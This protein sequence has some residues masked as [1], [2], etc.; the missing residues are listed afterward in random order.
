MKENTFGFVLHPLD[1]RRDTSRK[2]PFLARMPAW[3]IEFVS[4][5]APPVLLSEIK[6]IRSSGNGSELRGWFVACPLSAR[7]MLMLPRAI[8]YHK[9]VQSARLAETLGARIVGLGAFTSVVGDGGVSVAR[10]VNVPVTTGNSYT[11]ATAIHA[12]HLASQ[13]AG[14]DL[15]R[16][17]V[18]IVGAGG[19]IGAVCARLLA[20]DSDTLLLIGRSLPSLQDAARQAVAS[21]GRNVRVS[22]VI[23]AI[24]E[25]QVVITVTSS[26]S[27]VV[28]AHH[29]GPNAIVCDVARPRDVARR[30]CAKRPDVHV[31]EGGVV[32]VP[33]TV[34]FGFDFGFPPGMAYACMAETMALA[35]AGRYESFSLGKQLE[36]DRV[37]EIDQLA[38]RHGFRLS[39]L[40][41]LDRMVTVPGSDWEKDR[42]MHERRVPS[43]ARSKDVTRLPS[44]P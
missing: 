43:S 22:T 23:N 31:I 14:I 41:N 19:S 34:D 11:V 24:K 7:M 9:I 35:L 16:A 2:Y 1:A 21:G 32:R 27:A 20:Q 3:L 30:V 28:D 33:G 40:R 29:L 37:K 12:V 15:S 44:I 25:A 13:L 4:I 5:F 8:V 18:A 10:R 38:A 42:A 36:L 39:G 6:G 17:T 26:L